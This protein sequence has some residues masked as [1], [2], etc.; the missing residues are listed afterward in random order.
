MDTPNTLYR[1]YQQRAQSLTERTH[2][3]REHLTDERIRR[4]RVGIKRLRSLYRLIA[5]VRPRKFKRRRHERALRKLF[6]RAGHV[7]DLQVNQAA[8][9]RLSVPAEV[10]KQ[11]RLFLEKRE[12]KARKKLQKALVRFHKKD[13]KPASTLIRRLSKKADPATIIR[14]LRVFIDREAAAIDA[15][16]Q[17]GASP[18]RVHEARKHLK[19]LL[20]V[21]TLLVQ[22]TSDDSLAQIL[23]TAK[24]LQA[25]IGHWHDKIVLLQHLEAFI[26]SHSDLPTAIAE[27]LIARQHQL[28][29]VQFQ[30]IDRFTDSLRDLVEGLRPWRS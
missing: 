13:L 29:E 10:K 7:R 12:N 1:F 19:A 18:T 5:L 8:L 16:H 28:A 3:A 23:T 9:P 6:K 17:G 15:L 11:Y 27:R 22:L 4:L 14:R 20:E 21:G 30:P 25:Q 2:A 26:V 24:Q